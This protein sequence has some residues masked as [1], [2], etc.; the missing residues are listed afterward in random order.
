MRR[1]MLLGF[2][3]FAV[4]V[5]AQTTTLT[6]AGGAVTGCL[7]ILTMNGA[8]AS[9]SI[10]FGGFYGEDAYG[11]DM[12]FGQTVIEDCAITTSNTVATGPRTY[13]TTTNY[14]CP[15]SANTDGVTYHGTTVELQSKVPRGCGRQ[16][17]WA[18]V[19]NSGTT[20]LTAAQ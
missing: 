15:G 11:L 8:A 16:T 4:S 19:D 6:N 3:L 9:G 1:L 13:T 5:F 2:L 20:T 17:C 14:T 12:T 18:L 10:C 7:N